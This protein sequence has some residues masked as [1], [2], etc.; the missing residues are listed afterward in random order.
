[1]KGKNSFYMDLGLSVGRAQAVSSQEQK[2]WGEGSC[3]SVCLQVLAAVLVR[4]GE[5]LPLC[6]HWYVVY[7]DLAFWILKPHISWRAFRFLLE[8]REFIQTLDLHL[9]YMIDDIIY[10][11][12][13]SNI[14]LF[15]CRIN[16]TFWEKVLRTQIDNCNLYMRAGWYQEMAGSFFAGGA[17]WDFT[18]E[19]TFIYFLAHLYMTAQHHVFW[20]WSVISLIESTWI[21]FG[22]LFPPLYLLSGHLG[23]NPGVQACK[24][25]GRDLYN[26][27]F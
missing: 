25:S 24:E 1:M 11:H 15:L 13:L 7:R 22:A 23:M 19:W 6:N 2:G 26:H 18:L 14:F 10:N 12:R 9:T 27:S 5:N 16:F 20:A 17:V 8:V 21:D 4:K 3:S